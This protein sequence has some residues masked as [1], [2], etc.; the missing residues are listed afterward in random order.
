MII[1]KSSC[2]KKFIFQCIASSK[3]SVK[4]IFSLFERPKKYMERHV[5]FLFLK[6]FTTRRE[7][8]FSSVDNFQISKSIPGSGSGA[9]MTCVGI[10]EFCEQE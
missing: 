1:Q 10:C 7:V 8:F 2:R 6:F 3:Q 5:T 4:R 9:S